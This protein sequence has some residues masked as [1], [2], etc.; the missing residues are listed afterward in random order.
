VRNTFNE[1]E[2]LD[3]KVFGI[4]T[5]SPFTLDAFAKDHRL[6]YPLL[7]DYNKEVSRA[8]DCLY[9]EFLELKG[10][11]KR[12]AYVIDREGRIRYAH[13]CPDPRDLPDFEAI[14]RCLGQLP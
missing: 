5:D 8:Y 1:Y 13:V 14:K 9:D 11:S 6:Q 7:S 12:A 2:A 3:C 10:V 4:S